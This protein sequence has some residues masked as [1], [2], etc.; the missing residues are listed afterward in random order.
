MANL[1]LTERMGKIHTKKYE[2]SISNEIQNRFIKDKAA[3]AAEVVSTKARYNA[4][5]K[6]EL[7][8]P[9]KITSLI[10]QF[11]TTVSEPGRKLQE[12][13]KYLETQAP[14]DIETMFQSNL[15]LHM[16]ELV[17]IIKLETNDAQSREYEL[18]AR[19][20]HLMASN[21]LSNNRKL[22]LFTEKINEVYIGVS[23]ILSTLKT[24]LGLKTE[25][26]DDTLVTKCTL[27]GKSDYLLCGNFN[28]ADF[29]EDL[30]RAISD[31][32]FQVMC[33]TTH[34]QQ[35]KSSRE[36]KVLSVTRDDTQA[37]HLVAV[38]NAKL[39]Q[40]I[41][42][43]EDLLFPLYHTTYSFLT[44]LFTRY[45]VFDLSPFYML[46]LFKSSNL[47]DFDILKLEGYSYTLR[48]TGGP[49]MIVECIRPNN[50][51]ESRPLDT[52]AILL[53]CEKFNP[54]VSDVMQIAIFLQF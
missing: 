23:P 40:I 12:F 34:Y 47:I 24:L 27:K 6:R 51:V 18:I 17:E 1:R 45:R 52:R 44:V 37:N 2:A 9:S 10:N 19:S 54:Q 46:Q 48:E 28:P 38:T 7:E 13:A 21:R 42:A 25:I 16:L 50:T 31:R 39:G 49:Q 20:M 5:L 3:R 15:I 4:N 32:K 14:A 41:T 11:I 8:L 36:I 30:K 43:S 26:S 33:C 22:K 29:I 53:E 35:I